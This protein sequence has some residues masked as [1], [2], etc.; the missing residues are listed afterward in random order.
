M[1]LFL[2]ELFF[3]CLFNPSTHRALMLPTIHMAEQHSNNNNNRLLS[4]FRSL[5]VD[6]LFCRSRL[7]FIATLSIETKR[8]LFVT[9]KTQHDEREKNLQRK[10]K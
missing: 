7:L 2:S 1:T 9:T 6:E 5:V 3:C 8:N 4:S 10:E